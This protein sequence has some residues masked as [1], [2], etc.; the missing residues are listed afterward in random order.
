[1]MVAILPWV[2]VS[3]VTIWEVFENGATRSVM[4]SVLAI[5]DTGIG[6][7]LIL[8]QNDYL[9]SAGIWQND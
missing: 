9:G 7:L 5:V 8:F 4:A 6:M 3:H 1:M 2:G